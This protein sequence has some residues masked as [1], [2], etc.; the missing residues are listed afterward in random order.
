MTTL[1][2]E[3]RAELFATLN[4]AAEEERSSGVRYDD[5]CRPWHRQPWRR[6]TIPIANSRIKIR[7]RPEAAK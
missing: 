2:I 5:E 1:Y 7:S 3:V 6:R 4:A